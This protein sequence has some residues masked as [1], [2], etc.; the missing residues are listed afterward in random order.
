MTPQHA[1]NTYKWESAETAVRA[2]AQN[3]CTV[4][5]QSEVFMYDKNQFSWEKLAT[6]RGEISAWKQCMAAQ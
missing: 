6:L 1:R 2:A 5:M 3:A 4:D